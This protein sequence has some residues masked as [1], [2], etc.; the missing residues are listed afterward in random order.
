MIDEFEMIQ[1]ATPT[2]IT[3]TCSEMQVELPEIL[4]DVV[5]VPKT[6]L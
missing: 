6:T 4:S 1:N 3:N 2:T 5:M